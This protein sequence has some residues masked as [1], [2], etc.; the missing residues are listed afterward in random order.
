[1]FN[2]GNPHNVK[3]R[4]PDSNIVFLANSNT[5]GGCRWYKLLGQMFESVV[6]IIWFWESIRKCRK[7]VPQLPSEQYNPESSNCLS[8]LLSS[9]GLSAGFNTAALQ[10]QSHLASCSYT[11][12]AEI[13][14]MIHFIFHVAAELTV[15][16]SLAP[17]SRFPAWL[18]IMKVIRNEELCQWYGWSP[19]VVALRLPSSL[20]YSVPDGRLNCRCC[21]LCWSS[22]GSST[23]AIILFFNLNTSEAQL[24]HCCCY[25]LAEQLEAKYAFGRV[26]VSIGHR[27]KQQSLPDTSMLWRFKMML[28]HQ[29]F[30]H[31]PN[32]WC[33]G[34]IPPN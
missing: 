9:K 24:F 30:K 16:E 21:Q 8:I 33:A 5:H 19:R 1:M 2:M 6:H 7:V 11:A 17:I 27:N 25:S 14:L 4:I 26:L 12:N 29:S 32:R 28:L 13:R 31:P 23:R 18:L 10:P 20:S 22:Q 15:A 3:Y 34:V